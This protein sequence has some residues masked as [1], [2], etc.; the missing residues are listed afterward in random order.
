MHA[1]RMTRDGFY[2]LIQVNGIA[3]QAGNIRVRGDSMYLPGGMPGRAGG[4][5]VAFEQHGIFP[6]EFG[7]VKQNRTT[8]Y[9]TTDDDC[10]CMC[11]HKYFLNFYC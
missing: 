7:E 3:L 9:A 6:P 8:D 11:L 4:E 5:F 2:F 10:L 1:D